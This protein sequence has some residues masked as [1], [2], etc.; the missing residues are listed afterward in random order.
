MPELSSAI[1]LAAAGEVD[2]P[3][4]FISPAEGAGVVVVIATAG[5][6]AK[7]RIALKTYRFMIC[8]SLNLTPRLASLGAQS[9]RLA[10]DIDRSGRRVDILVLEGMT[11]ARRHAE[12]S[13]SGGNA[14][15][16]AA[17][18]VLDAAPRVNKIRRRDLL[19]AIGVERRSV[20]AVTGHDIDFHDRTTAAVTA[21]VGVGNERVENDS[22]CS[23]RW[24]GHHALARR[25]QVHVPPFLSRVVTAHGDR[26]VPAER[27]VEGRC[28][29]RVGGNAVGIAIDACRRTYD[30]L[31]DQ[32]RSAAHSRSVVANT[33]ESLLVGRR[34]VA[35]ID[36][37][38]GTERDKVAAL[39]ELGHVGGRGG[40]LAPGL[41]E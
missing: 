36:I 30:L 17:A 19:V 41:V 34:V 25:R 14:R 27:S 23:N 3:C 12:E 11:S 2:M 26:V 6:A 21:W 35:R 15:D 28:A 37:A 4:I 1:A 40:G 22:T 16:H 10:N 8:L 20:V 7:S 18:G 39:R 13:S 9:G 29:D 5:A 38:S 24:I 31:A 32:I 33:V